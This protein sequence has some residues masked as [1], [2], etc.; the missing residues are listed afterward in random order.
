MDLSRCFPIRVAFATALGL[1]TFLSVPSATGQELRAPRYNNPISK[2]ARLVSPKL[3]KV[4]DRM[5]WL[6]EETN[7]LAQYHQFPLRYN[8][9]YRGHRATED[10]PDPFIILDF[11]KS[12][13]I[14]R[15]FLIP[16]Q[17]EYL[18]DT[19]IFPRL[20][21][22]ELANEADFSDAH[23]IFTT[24]DKLFINTNGLPVDFN[25]GQNGRYL[26]L[27][28]HRGHNKGSFDVYGLAEIF[29][30]SEGRPVSF[31]SQIK[32]F[33]DLEISPV[34]QPAALIDGRSPLGIWHHGGSAGSEIGDMV[35]VINRGSTTSW[36]LDLNGTQPID[37]II[38]FPYQ[39]GGSY[40]T[41]VFPDSLR[42]ELSSEDASGSITIREW[43]N[44]LPSSNQHSP[45]VF[46]FENTTA[47]K[48]TITATS[49]WIMSER[50]MHALSEIQIW[51]GD[52]NLAKGR[53]ITRKHDDEKTTVT[54]LTDGFSSERNI[55]PIGNWLEQLIKRGQINDELNTLDAIHR[56]LS[57]R[58]ELNVS[59]AAAV[60]LG[61][62]FLIPVFIFEHKRIK[63]KE[64]L[65]IIRKRIAADLHDDIGSNLGSISMIARTAR[66][67]LARLNGPAE[68]D[69]D[70]GE[71]EIIARE[72]SL[73][74]RDIVWLLERK[75]DSIGDLVHR[76]RETA[77]RLLRGAEFTLECTSTKTAAKLTLDAK[78]HLF[79]FYKEAIHNIV[80]HSQATRVS[81]RLWDEQGD[82]LAMEII[83][84]GVGLPVNA[85]KA[86]VSVKKLEERTE[87]MGGRIQVK[88][89][90]E[91]GTTIRLLVKRSKLTTPSTSS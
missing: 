48:V 49:H 73:A 25:G 87:V 22:L 80:K 44:P 19:G 70:L 1:M 34:W 57:T 53:S 90:P 91:K 46:A 65:D 78:R 38:L 30:F 79:L 32:T 89:S 11:G 37:Q 9:G 71:V 26:R 36:Q 14:D 21:T 72:S 33:G 7:S 75:Q 52:D 60:L 17:R 12:L 23:T 88:S 50:T 86:S 81:I 43:N 15:I 47:K 61:L 6:S 28:V 18:N 76:M 85:N 45:L 83:D 58:G 62:T 63:S 5:S 39:I 3:A 84:N 68:I 4:E 42:I 67:D 77:G 31:N 27:T 35:P 41:S 2:L 64:Q 69:N 24:Q 40:Y 54:S 29:V 55:A 82:Q 66:K 20:F 51:S 16:T 8:I 59:W 56:Q 74:M 10:A 13:P